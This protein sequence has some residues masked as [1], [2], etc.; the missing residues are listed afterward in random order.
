MSLNLNNYEK[1]MLES[2]LAF[3]KGVKLAR[4][5]ESEKK[6]NNLSDEYFEIPDD[7]DEELMN[8]QF[9]AQPRMNE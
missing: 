2:K 5:V 6:K 8:L 7:I 1:A 3:Q 9:T 4:L